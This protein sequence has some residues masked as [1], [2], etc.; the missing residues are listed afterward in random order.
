MVFE[1]SSEAVVFQVEAGVARIVLN[2][3]K[4]GNAVTR[5]MAKALS[6]IWA[7]VG[8]DPDIRV[9]IFRGAGERHLCTGAAAEA[10][11]SQAGEARRMDMPRSE[12]ANWTARHCGIWK[13][14]ICIVNGLVAGGGL[15]HV[16]DADIVVA[17]AHAQFM[18]THVNVG[19]VGA[20]DAIGVA[21]RAGLG[22]ALTMTLAGKGYRMDAARAY[23]LGLADFLEPTVEAAEAR[24][25][26]LAQAIC[27]AS[28][29]AVELSQRAIWESLEMSHEAAL[30]HGWSL[31]KSHWPHP[32]C[33]E[34]P[35]AFQERRKPV[36]AR[37]GT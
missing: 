22:A 23:Q 31:I 19:Q 32:D 28:P 17:A 14:V 16:V 29:R 35:R 20:L 10:L 37:G 4:A 26:A 24:A 25:L 13:P 11:G 21:K 33:T 12:G 27:E 30:E 18:D 5:A 7:E 9:A 34:G 3:P 36:W 2:R 15:H 8:R 6:E 1:S